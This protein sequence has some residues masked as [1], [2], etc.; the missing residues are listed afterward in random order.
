MS[1]RESL[2]RKD[3]T[4]R[5]AFAIVAMALAFGASADPLNPNT[6][7]MPGK[8]MAFMHYLP[9]EHERGMVDVFDVNGLKSQLIEMGVDGFMFTLGQNNNFYNAPNDAYR[10]I[11]G[12]NSPTSFSSRDLPAEIIAALKGTGIR[13]GLYSPCQ[14]SFNDEVAERAFGFEQMRTDAAT[15]WYMTDRGAMTWA[16]VISEWAERYGTDVAIWWFDGAR[17]DMRFSERHGKILREAL[18]R[19]NPNMAV[20]FNWGLLDWHTGMMKDYDAC[21]EK[22]PTFA[23]R[24]PFRKFTGSGTPVAPRQWLASSDYISGEAAEPFRFMPHSRWLEGNQYFILTYL[25]HYWGEPHNRYPDE[26]WIRYLRT[27]LKNGGS[28]AIDMAIDRATGRFVDCHV[29][30]MRRILRACRVQP[31]ADLVVAKDGMTNYSVV[32]PDPLPEGMK[33]VVED[34][35]SLFQ[36]ASGARLPVCASARAHRLFIGICPPGEALPTDQEHGVKTVGNVIYLYGGGVNGTRLAVYDFLIHDLGF[37][38]FDF[39]G[40]IRIPDLRTCRLAPVSRRRKPSF[41]FRYLNGGTGMFNRPE[42][43]LFLFRNAQNCWSERDLASDGI[44]V[45]KDDCRF[46]P[47]HAH[48]LRLYLPADA[49]EPTF[50]WIREQGGPDLKSVHPEYFTLNANGQRVFDHQYCFSNPGLRQLLADRILENMRRNPDFRVF[51]VS[52]GDTD[53]A[54]CHCEG[55]KALVAK[56]GSEG[57]PLYDF[58]LAFCP[59]AESLFPSNKVMV[60]AYR[61]NQTQRPPR[62]VSRFP[63]NF[64]P[65]FAPIDD[66][67]AKDWTH[68]S[69]VA[70]YDDLKGWTSLCKDVMVWYYP[71]TYGG[72]VTPP[73]GNVERGVVDIR[74]MADAGVTAHLWEHNVGVAWG[75]GFTELQSYV[76]I[77]L[78]S[79]VRQDWRKLADE[80]IDFEYGAAADGFRKYWL[81]LEELRRK[82]DLAFPWNA[83]PAAYRHLTPARLMRWNEAFDEMERTVA[84]DGERLFAIRRVR[85]NL[86]FALLYLFGEVKKR[87]FDLSADALADRILSTAN[88]AVSA[89]CAPRYAACGRGFLKSLTESVET[90]KVVNSGESKPLPPEIFG[91]YHPDRLFVS[92][93]KVAGNA[94]ERDADAAFGLRAVFTDGRGLGR[95]KGEGVRLPLHASFE[96]VTDRSKYRFDIARVT[97]DELPPRGK[98]RFY[99]MGEGVL[100]P[101]CVFRIGVDDSCDFKTQLGNAWEFGSRNRVK[102]YASLK[103]EGPAFYPEESDRE[104][105]VFCDRVVVVRE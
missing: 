35:V 90:M 40:G 49:K 16:N 72:D 59:R 18:I 41:R 29:R 91:S 6:D 14:P 4:R 15:D 36:K 92:I 86:D 53:G 67:F 95:R 73:V 63:S 52:A 21:C 13:F 23:E 68:R 20:S 76:Y 83:N 19:A 80:F 70:T 42:S 39:H 66:N 31:E 103:F 82:T 28:I 2:A 75:L 55:C 1:A 38:F 61:R 22:D 77:R 56:Y 97:R 64:M 81:E 34:F 89:F 74:L 100:S 99:A 69:N 78:M 93:P 79:D 88:K 71:N 27:F 65:N 50:G 3:T 11:A 26:I 17:P 30:Q 104:S 5:L 102:F 84:A 45:P 48:S 58:M 12:T 101:D 43:S 7:W 96:D 54:F 8:V 10:K 87:G 32:V 57:G 33:F 25:G 24:V 62:G 9:K 60:L 44:L 47:P 85:L 51:D 105:R 46:L 94:Y 37:R 98:Y